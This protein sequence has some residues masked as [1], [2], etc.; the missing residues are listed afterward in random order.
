[1]KAAS[2]ELET[3]MGQKIFNFSKP[4]SLIKYLATL[5]LSP[6]TSAGGGGGTLAA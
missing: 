5:V 6:S 4:V 1:M 2:T 3:L